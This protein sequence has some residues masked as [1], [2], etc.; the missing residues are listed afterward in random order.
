MVYLARL[1]LTLTG[2]WG[3]DM[4]ISYVQ[5]HQQPNDI[6]LEVVAGGL[7]ASLD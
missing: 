2:S 3:W 7:E 1:F 4:S 6:T 5:V